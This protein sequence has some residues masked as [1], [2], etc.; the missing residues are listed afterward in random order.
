MQK[1]FLQI[2]QLETEPR[3]TTKFTVLHFH[4]DTSNL[5]NT[6]CSILEVFQKIFLTLTC[7][8]SKEGKLFKFP[9]TLGMRFFTRF[10]KKNPLLVCTAYSGTNKFEVQSTSHDSHTAFE[11]DCVSKVIQCNRTR[12][13]LNCQSVSCSVLCR[14]FPDKKLK[15][16]LIICSQGV[17]QV[18][19]VKEGH[20]QQ[21]I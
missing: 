18:L 13:C 7:T 4:T 17:K 15:Q 1:I 11:L 6:T 8:I 19:R 20:F 10:H 9:T 2:I 14:L 16:Y 12:D 3:S 5:Y 21:L